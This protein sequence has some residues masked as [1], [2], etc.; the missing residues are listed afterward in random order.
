MEKFLKAD[1][2]KMS[3]KD[4]KESILPIELNEE[5]KDIY[6]SLS[7]KLTLDKRKNV[8]TLGERIKKEIKK[9]EDEIFRVKNM[10]DFDK[11]F[12]EEI[13]AGVD[14]VGRGPLA[15]PIVAAA[16]ILK[17]NPN[18]KELL[19]GVKDSKALSEEKREELNKIIKE[20]AIS[21]S[22]AEC[23]HDDIDSKGIAFC[24]NDIFKRS[25]EGLNIE[26]DLVLSDGYRVKGLDIK[27]EAVIKGDAKSIS[28]AAASIIAKV[29]RDNLMKEYANKYP[30]Y[31]FE[32]NVGYGSK[33]HIETLQKI[34]PCPIH[35]V[36]FLSNILSK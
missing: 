26:P 5:N 33:N 10:Y 17:L 16:V 11:S 12:G 27:N 6:V 1:L 28:I 8:L 9:Y 21:Y 30:E 13:V 2:G 29:Y 35:R 18:D 23:S 31:G 32:K 3:F 19:L 34:G 36:S 15:G 20:K 14:E 22:I 7:D 4:I 25:I 24:N